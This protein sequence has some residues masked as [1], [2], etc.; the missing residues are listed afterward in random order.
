MKKDPSLNEDKEEDDNIIMSDYLKY[1]NDGV[2]RTDAYF[3]TRM[4]EVRGVLSFY[5]KFI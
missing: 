5:K 4:G 2:F 3:C 1:G